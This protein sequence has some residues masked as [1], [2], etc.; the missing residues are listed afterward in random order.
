MNF[1]LLQLVSNSSKGALKVEKT[2]LKIKK[3][4]ASRRGSDMRVAITFGVT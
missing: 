2:T 3:K 4:Q 1:S